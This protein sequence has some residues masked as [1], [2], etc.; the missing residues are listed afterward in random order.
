MKEPHVAGVFIIFG[1]INESITTSDIIKVRQNKIRPLSADCVKSVLYMFENITT[2]KKTLKRRLFIFERT[3][4]SANLKWLISIPII[5][6]PAR[7]ATALTQ[8]IK[9]SN[10][11]FPPK[12]VCIFDALCNIIILKINIQ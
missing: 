8:I 3:S 4:S 7:G 12:K 5:M 6:Y 11:I 1:T 10:F 2:G 9:F